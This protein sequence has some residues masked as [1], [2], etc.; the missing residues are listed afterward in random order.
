MERTCQFNIEVV[1]DRKECYHCG[2]DPEVA[3]ARKEEFVR[4]LTGQKLYKV[5]FTGYCEVW[6]NTPEEA[7][8][9]AETVERQFTASYE[10]GEPICLEKEEENE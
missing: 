10:Y 1:C 2:W 8:E 6:A 3:K 7:A 5:P 4:K 9:M